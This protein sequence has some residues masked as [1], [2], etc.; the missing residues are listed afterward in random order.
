VF[1]NTVPRTTNHNAPA[2]AWFSATL[3]GSFFVGFCNLCHGLWFVQ[4][5]FCYK[6]INVYYMYDKPSGL[7]FSNVSIVLITHR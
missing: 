5:A 4:T 2:F 1:T 7:M 6:H 3:V